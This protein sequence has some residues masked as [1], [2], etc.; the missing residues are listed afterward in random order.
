MMN[1]VDTGENCCRSDQKMRCFIPPAVLPKAN[2]APNCCL[3]KVNTFG[4]YIHNRREYRFYSLAI[5]AHIDMVLLKRVFHYFIA[6]LLFIL[7]LKSQA[8]FSF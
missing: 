8:I 7:P 6:I 3:K 5:S 4:G 1:N 2:K